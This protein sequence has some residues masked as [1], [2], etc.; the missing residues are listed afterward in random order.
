MKKVIVTL[1]LMVGLVF[2]DQASAQE[3]LKQE[4][5]GMSVKETVEAL[6]KKISAK[7]LTIFAKI[8]HMAAAKN[9]ELNMKPAV[10]LIFGNPK[11]G[12]E[13]MN[14]NMEWSYELPL[15]IAVYE[16][17]K[18]KVW[19][20]SRMLPKDLAAPGQEK[21]IEAMNALIKSI[22]LPSKGQT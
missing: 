15:K 6:E 5:S 9:A 19:L 18:G 7:G 20:Q 10:V 11:V 21:R 22:M 8:N 13:L 16:D 2:A 3:V 1:L 17:A 12:T 4:I 14:A